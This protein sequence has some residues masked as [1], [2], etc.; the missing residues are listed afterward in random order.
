MIGR[1]EILRIT[2]KSRNAYEYALLDVEGQMPV[3][4]IFSYELP[5]PS[6]V[7]ATLHWKNQ[8][9]ASNENKIATYS[10]NARS[11]ADDPCHARISVQVD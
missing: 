3:Y 8:N 7:N 4:P 11:P 5:L 10:L 9:P 2:K 6:V 1:T